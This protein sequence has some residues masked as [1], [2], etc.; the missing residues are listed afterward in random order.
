MNIYTIGHSTH[1][2]EDFINMLAVSHIQAV[3]DVRSFP[4]S[5]KFPHFSKDRMQEWLPEAG[6]EYIHF[7]SLGGRRKQSQM[8]QSELNGA[9]NNQSFHNYAD[10]TLSLDFQKGIDAL[11]Q[12]ASKKRTAYCCSERHPSRCHRLLVSNWLAANG[13]NVKHII[14][15]NK[16]QVEVLEHEQGKWGAMP[17]IEPDGTVVYPRDVTNTPS[18]SNES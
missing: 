13:W 14:D 4:G 18:S 1:S 16:G 12:M 6:F 7:P 11:K 9:W 8:I 15:G 10:Y 2:K 5:R 3:V 17:I